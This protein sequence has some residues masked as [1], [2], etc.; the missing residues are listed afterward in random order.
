M[1]LVCVRRQGSTRYYTDI[2]NPSGSIFYIFYEEELYFAKWPQARTSGKNTIVAVNIT[3]TLQ[4]EEY[5]ANV[6]STTRIEPY[7]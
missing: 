1:L 7:I 4:Q 5:Q 3:Y 2:C 6:Y